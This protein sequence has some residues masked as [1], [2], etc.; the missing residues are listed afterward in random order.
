M[1][2]SEMLKAQPKRGSGCK[3]AVWFK[4]LGEMDQLAVQQAFADEYTSTSHIVR[5]LQAYGCP[6]SESTIRTH[7]LNE[8][9]SC[10]D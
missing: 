2:L 10:Q 5:T 1:N 6:M 7:R 3:W 9:K 8:C 4:S